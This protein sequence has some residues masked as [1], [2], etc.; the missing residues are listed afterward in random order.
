MPNYDPIDWEISHDT[1]G[2]IVTCQRPILLGFETEVINVSH[3]K[4]ELQIKDTDVTF[5]DWGLSLIHI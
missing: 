3:F 1:H 2:R 5:D 4:C